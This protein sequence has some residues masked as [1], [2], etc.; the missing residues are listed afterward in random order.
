M[1]VWAG[2]NKPKCVFRMTRNVSDEALQ[3]FKKYIILANFL[4]PHC[5]TDAFKRSGK[6]P[7]ATALLLW[8]KRFEFCGEKPFTI[9]N[10]YDVC[11]TVLSLVLL[12][13]KK[14]CSMDF[15]RLL[16]K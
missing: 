13:A 4:L 16:Q 15:I 9:L 10:T 3:N 2:I 12:Y 7:T 1:K 14:S 6:L 8:R 11:A 5:L